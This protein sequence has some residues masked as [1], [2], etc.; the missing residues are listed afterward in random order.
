MKN[1]PKKREKKERGK[2]QTPDR[3]KAKEMGRRL[4]TNK[5]VRIIIHLIHRWNLG[6]MSGELVFFFR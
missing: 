2:E 6:E 1:S 4:G 5:L 3:E